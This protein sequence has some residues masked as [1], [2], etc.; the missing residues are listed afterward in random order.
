[1]NKIIKRLLSVLLCFIMT[2]IVLDSTE[3]ISSADSASSLRDE[4]A[5]LQAE[6]Q[7][8][9]AEIKRLKNEK[10]SQSVILSAIQ[11]KIANIQA[12]VLRCN[13]EINSINAKIDAN[14][15]E[16]DS[17]N[18]EIE[19]NK[20]AFKKR[21]RAIYMSNTGSSIQVLMGADDFADFLQLSQLV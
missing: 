9:E 12:Q 19:A 20:L 8:I 2:F 15:K 10:Q 4:I 3:W 6:S 18:A 17:K 21:L 11:K 13:K 14:K 16:I 7:K 1:M 5:G